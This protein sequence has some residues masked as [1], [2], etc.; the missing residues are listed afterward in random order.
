MFRAPLH[1]ACQSPHSQPPAG[2]SG[3]GFC[4]PDQLRMGKAKDEG[5]SMKVHPQGFCLAA[6]IS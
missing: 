1:M 6:L 3:H 5:D 4:D 2:E